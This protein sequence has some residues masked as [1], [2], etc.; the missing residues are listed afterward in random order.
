MNFIKK[1]LLIGMGIIGFVFFGC[2]NGM[3][4]NQDGNQENLG[5]ITLDYNTSVYNVSMKDALNRSKEF[6]SKS[7]KA[8]NSRKAFVE[9][10]KEDLWQGFI[11]NKYG[12]NWNVPSSI[13]GTSLEAA[14]NELI[15]NGEEL[16]TLQN[17]VFHKDEKGNFTKA[18]FQ[19]KDELYYVLDYQTGNGS[20]LILSS[21][22]DYEHIC[23]TQDG[24]TDSPDFSN[25]KIWVWE[26]A[27]D[28]QLYR[29]GNLGYA[30]TLRNVQMLD[31]SYA[32][33]T[34]SGFNYYYYGFRVWIKET[35]GKSVKTEYPKDSTDSQTYVPQTLTDFAENGSKDFI[36]KIVNNT[37][38]K[39]TVANYI[40][41]V[42]MK[43]ED[44][45]LSKIA[46]SEDVVIENGSSYE[47]K[48]NLNTLKNK[49]G[50]DKYIGC[51]FFPEGKWRCSG[52]ENSFDYVYNIHTVTVTDSENTKNC[53]DA[54]NSWQ[55][56]DKEL[57]NVDEQTFVNA[58]YSENYSDG[59]G[60]NIPATE[61]TK[62]KVTEM[63]FYSTGDRLI[64]NAANVFDSSELQKKLQEK[65]P[66]C[67]LWISAF[68]RESYTG[69]MPDNANYGLCLRLESKNCNVQ[70]VWC[71]TVETSILKEVYEIM[72][73]S[74]SD[75]IRN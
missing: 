11:N 30:Y 47:F 4:S 53:M 42:N 62:W 8:Q 39:L 75:F 59:W 74:A 40:R 50:T 43:T 14:E 69:W 10:D 70:N 44:F 54:V 61:T 58:V 23:F 21:E 37:S 60:V 27:A 72:K 51:N 66:D 71:E 17:L 41:D 5:G 64:Y 32:T 6:V 7:V 46:V 36:Y 55:I 12:T 73:N 67:K 15:I 49:Y 1:L 9:P 16:G 34:V 26:Y 52:W 20:Y 65:I 18:V 35:D 25:F 45:N 13:Y 56:I 63:W 68:A 31:G 19:Y 57:S 29:N 28:G 24:K 33:V 38:G 48:Y 2:N 3:N 22:D